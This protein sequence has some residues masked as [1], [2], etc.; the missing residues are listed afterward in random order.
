M[1]NELKEQ[2]NVVVDAREKA[3]EATCLRI[4]S[5]NKWMEANESIFDNEKSAKCDQDLAEIK[6][7]EMTLQSYTETGNKAPEIG[8]GIRVKSVLSYDHKEALVWAVDHTIALKLDTAS[9]ERFAKATPL[10]FIT[11]TEEYQATI[12]TELKK[13]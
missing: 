11:I 6:L 9:F 12:A 4:V 1:G 3:R 10:N 5:F 13:V 7:R 8:V 2:I